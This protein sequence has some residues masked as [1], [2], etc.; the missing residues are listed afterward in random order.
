MTDTASGTNQ[1]VRRT[2]ARR[3]AKVARQKS[4]SLPGQLALDLAGYDDDQAP[5]AA[6]D[7][8]DPP[9]PEDGHAAC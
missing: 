7:L 4:L 3:P 5:S 2:S 9:D 6:L 8:Q 1:P